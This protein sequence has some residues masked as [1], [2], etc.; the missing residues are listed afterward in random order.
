MHCT[1]SCRACDKIRRGPGNP[2]PTPQTL[3]VGKDSPL[4]KAGGMELEDL[5]MVDLP[6]R[7]SGEVIHWE[8]PILEAWKISESAAQATLDEFANVGRFMPCF[9]D[10]SPAETIVFS[11]ISLSQVRKD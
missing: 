4:Q 8:K 11:S 10:T 1:P 7:K 5:G 2:I 6:K 9:H 3:P